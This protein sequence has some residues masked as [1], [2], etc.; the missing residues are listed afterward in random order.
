M[1]RAKHKEPEKCDSTQ[2][3]ERRFAASVVFAVL[4]RINN[5]PGFMKMFAW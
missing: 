5:Q 3:D 2:E 1:K 4:L